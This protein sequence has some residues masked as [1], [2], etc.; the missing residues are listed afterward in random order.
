M[1]RRIDNLNLRIIAIAVFCAFGLSGCGGS[2]E[3]TIAGV[4]VPVPK[5][6][7]RSSEAPVEMKFFGFGAGSGG[8]GGFRTSDSKPAQ[9]EEVGA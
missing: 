7:T 6:M 9:C 4:A 3:D 8:R 1:L 2:Y 5:S